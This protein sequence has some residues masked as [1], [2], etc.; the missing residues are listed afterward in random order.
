MNKKQ[1]FRT[2]IPFF[3]FLL[4]LTSGCSLITQT[5]EQPPRLS[6]EEQLR[7]SISGLTPGEIASLLDEARDAD[8]IDTCW[9]PLIIRCLESGVEI[10]P[11]HV[12]LAVKSFNQYQYTGH[13][14]KAVARYFH[15]MIFT[16]GGR[17]VEYGKNDKEFLTAYIRYNLSNCASKDC[18]PLRVSQQVCQRL[19]PD[20]YRKFFE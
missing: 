14:H 11:R 3:L 10:P 17:R 19:D 12:K 5:K 7:Q 16:N 2:T 15:N 13:F 18:Q 1:F 9:T 4:T 6:C 20:L 8:R